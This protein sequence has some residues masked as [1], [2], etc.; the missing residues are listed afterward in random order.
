MTSPIDRMDTMIQLLAASNKEY[1]YT[2]T[3]PRETYETF[4]QA[5]KG[6]KSYVR[7]VNLSNLN[8]IYYKGI[9]IRPRTALDIQMDI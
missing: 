4:L 3:V 1:P 5:L 2:I 8:G 6:N 7:W 9:L